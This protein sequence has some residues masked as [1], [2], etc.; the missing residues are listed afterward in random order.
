MDEP[1]DRMCDKAASFAVFLALDVFGILDGA[2]AGWERYRLLWH[3]CVRFE[4]L[5]RRESSLGNIVCALALTQVGRCFAY[6]SL[7]LAM[8]MSL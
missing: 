6:T 3:Q 5:S 2:A 4:S 7:P 1:T 8:A